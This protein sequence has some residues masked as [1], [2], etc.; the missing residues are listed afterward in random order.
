V[1]YLPSKSPEIPTLVILS[2]GIVSVNQYTAEILGVR[3]RGESFLGVIRAL[4]VRLAMGDLGRVILQWSS[5]ALL[6]SLLSGLYLWWPLKRMRIGGARWSARFW[7]DL[8]SS[9]GFFSLIPVLLL[10][11]TGVVMGFENE[12]TLLIDRVSNSQPVRQSPF[13]VASTSQTVAAEITPDQAL[14]IAMAQVPGA[15]PYRVQMPR[16]GGF[17]V[18]ALE[19]PENRVTGERNFISVDPANGRIVSLKLSSDLKFRE[20]FFAFNG[21]I[22]T[23]SF[24]GM[25]SKI[26]AALASILL[27]VQGLSGL[28]IWLRRKGLLHRR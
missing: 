10:A 16:Y 22:H 4:H 2:R 1:A 9:I 12:F 26:I 23:G 3:T 5:L 11:G 13:A 17:Y 15:L 19:Y 25:P 8:H 14:A 28:L 18:V 7:Y 20:R 27:P 21:T 6:V 24:W